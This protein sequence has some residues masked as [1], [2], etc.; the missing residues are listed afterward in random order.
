[1]PLQDVKMCICVYAM[2]NLIHAPKLTNERSERENCVRNCEHFLHWNIYTDVKQKCFSRVFVLGCILLRLNGGFWD[3]IVRKCYVLDRERDWS[4]KNSRKLHSLS[5]QFNHL[6]NLLVQ[7]CV[8]PSQYHLT[9]VCV[10]CLPHSHTH[11]PYNRFYPVDAFNWMWILQS[12]MR[13]TWI[14]ANT[15]RNRFSFMKMLCVHVCSSPLI[16]LSMIFVIKVTFK[17]S[18]Q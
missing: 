12:N 4:K 15:K 18:F 7:H 6:C 1:M 5:F 13:F 17:S 9:I 11:T 14:N 3:W 8:A 16:F 2:L 10:M